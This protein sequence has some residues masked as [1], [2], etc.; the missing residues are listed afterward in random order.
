MFWDSEK[1]GVP[2]DPEPWGGFQ[3]LNWPQG[4][5]RVKRLAWQR[6]KAAEQVDCSGH[7]SRLYQGSVWRAER[8]GWEI[9]SYRQPEM[10]MDPSFWASGPTAFRGKRQL[11]PV[12][13]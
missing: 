9:W 2:C 8:L 7:G 1:M 6:D 5:L 10:D 11:S 12:H 13:W 4:W 3:E